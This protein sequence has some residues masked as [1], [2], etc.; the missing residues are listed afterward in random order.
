MKSKYACW[1]VKN[2][3]N[4]WNVVK[5]LTKGE[6]KPAGKT[7]VSYGKQRAIVVKASLATERAFDLCSTLNSRLE[8]D[9]A[10]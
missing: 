10:A 8:A 5:L 1:A 9:E 7:L 4:L 2:S 6:R 3:T